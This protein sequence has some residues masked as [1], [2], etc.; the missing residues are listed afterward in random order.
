MTLEDLKKIYDNMEYNIYGKDY[1]SESGYCKYY[2]KDIYNY[3][4]RNY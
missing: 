4:K 2:D 1:K 3:I